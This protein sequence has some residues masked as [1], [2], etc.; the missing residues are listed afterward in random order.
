MSI[1]SL[2]LAEPAEPAL[3]IGTSATVTTPHGEMHLMGTNERT[4]Q[5]ILAGPDGLLETTPDELGAWQMLADTEG[6]R[7]AEAAEEL[8]ETVAESFLE[9]PETIKTKKIMRP[10][11]A[12]AVELSKKLDEKTSAT[13]D[14]RTGE[15]PEDLPAPPDP[16]DESEDFD[17]GD[18]DEPEDEP[19]LTEPPEEPPEEPPDGHGLGDEGEPDDGGGEPP[20]PDAAT[21][22]ETRARLAH[23]RMEAVNKALELGVEDPVDYLVKARLSPEMAKRLQQ[24]SWDMTP[25]PENETIP[26]RDPVLIES[27]RGDRSREEGNQIIRMIEDRA[28][29]RELLRALRRPGELLFG[30][31]HIPVIG[32]IGRRLGRRVLAWRIYLRERGKRLQRKEFTMTDGSKEVREI[33]YNDGMVGFGTKSVR[34]ILNGLESLDGS[35][36]VNRSKLSRMNRHKVMGDLIGPRRDLAQQIDKD[37]RSLLKLGVLKTKRLGFYEHAPFKAR[38]KEYEAYKDPKKIAEERNEF[39]RLRF[40]EVRNA[41]QQARFEA[42]LQKHPNWE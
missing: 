2:P 35:I 37:I 19:E 1:E 14:G 9:L 41:E 6:F 5:V 13:G 20:E 26:P 22:L 11:G 38:L 3:E 29:Q 8:G 23:L 25:P 12:L 31:G 17:W 42:L 33:V 28:G 24:R 40:L 16:G 27:E 15:P 39:V 32:N 30:L 4:G 10:I 36:V 18:E 21:D 7:K 34:E